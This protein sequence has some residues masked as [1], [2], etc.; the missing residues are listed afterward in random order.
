MSKNKQ[1]LFEM[2]GKSKFPI[3]WVHPR[4]VPFVINTFPDVPIACA[5][6]NK[7]WWVL[8][9]EESF[10][11]KNDKYS[12]YKVMVNSEAKVRKDLAD[13]YK[14]RENCNRFLEDSISSD[15]WNSISE[16]ITLLY[17]NDG[18]RYFFTS[19]LHADLRK[20]S[21]K[22]NRD[23]R[24]AYFLP[25]GARIKANGFTGALIYPKNYSID[26]LGFHNNL[27]IDWELLP[28]QIYPI[29]ESW[30]QRVI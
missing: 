15:L 20:H 17:A 30:I 4:N 1:K 13:Y 19:K 3:C 11:F 27:Q 28:N 22:Y 26:E 23:D 6:G 16:D 9:G 7:K 29:N 2:M 24:P 14:N 25:Q 21:N 10:V 8:N 12:S 5:V 18:M